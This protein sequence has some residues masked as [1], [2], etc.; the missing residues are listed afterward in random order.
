MNNLI[1]KI[2]PD[3][4]RFARRMSRHSDTQNELIQSTVLKCYE[5][6]SKVKQMHA[7]GKLNGWLFTVIRNEN[8]KLVTTNAVEAPKELT[9]IPYSDRIEEL[10]P[11]LT[12]IEKK[13]LKVYVECDGSYTKIEQRTTISRSHASKRIK[14]IIEKCKQ[15]KF[16]LE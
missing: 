2:L 4:E 9:D 1:L 12:D 8:L 14:S 6:E 7:E 5:Y 16:I 15:L 3:I 11:F 13:W 10:K